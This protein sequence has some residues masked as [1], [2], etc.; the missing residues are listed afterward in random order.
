MGLG[1]VAEIRMKALPKRV[2][3]MLIETSEFANIFRMVASPP[4]ARTTSALQP[5]AFFELARPI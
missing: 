5:P 4:D 3:I 2:T 1:A